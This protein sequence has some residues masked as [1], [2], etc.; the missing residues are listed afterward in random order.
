MDAFW[1]YWNSLTQGARD[2][3]VGGLIVVGVIGAFKMMGVPLLAGVRS[4]ARW[5]LRG[6]RAVETSLP[7][8]PQVV[9]IR[10]PIQPVALPQTPS[11]E[12]TDKGSVTSTASSHLIPHPPIV[13]FVARRDAEGREILACLKEEL[14]PEKTQ[15]VAL[16]GAGG[17]GKTTLAAESVRALSEGYAQRVVWVSA[18][19]RPDFT[20]A[21]L[22]DEIAGQLGHPEVRPL[23]LEQK[24][25]QLRGLVA[26]APT[27]I[28]LDNF[29]TIAETEQAHCADWLAN[30]ASC[31]AII[32]SRDY[33]PHARPVNIAAMSI[34]EAQEFVGRLIGQ[35]RHPQSFKG[36]ERDEII[37]AADR[38]PL[39]LQWII[40][41]IDLA[42]QPHTV[43]NELAQ[44]KGDA[45]E[46]V[47]GRSFDLL[48]D[49]GRAALLALSLFVPSASRRALAE[50]A[51]FGEDAPRL[52]AAAAQLAELWLANPTEGNERFIVEG[53][54]RELAKNLLS[55]DE[56]GDEFRQRFVAHFLRYAEAHANTTPEDFDALEAEKDNILSAMDVA[57]SLEDWPGVIRLMSAIN[58]DGVN[59]LLTIRGYWDEAIRRGEQALKA[60]H[61]LRNEA[62]IARFAHNTAIIF[63]QR[64]EMSEARRIYGESLKI[65]KKLG[66]QKGIASTL[67]ELA[68]LAQAQGELEEARRLY[69]ESLEIN[70]KLDN[71]RE[72]AITLHQLA[73]LAQTQG[74]LEKAR[75]LYDESLEINKKL[76]NHREIAITLHQLATLAQAQGAVEQARQ[77]YG[78]SLEISEKLSNQ[79]VIALSLHNL[80]IIAQDQ[81]ELEEARRLYDESLEIN[82]K[83]GSQSGIAITLH[84]LA[85]LAQTQGELEKARRLYDESLE[86]KKKLGDR[87]GIASTLHELARLAQT[88]GKLEKARRLYDE[89]LEIKKK[90]GDRSGI[91]NTLAQLGSLA[92]QEGDKVEAERLLWESLSIFE[93]LKSPNAEI[94]RRNLAR[95]GGEAS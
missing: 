1:Q 26:A 51:G 36:L 70:K 17:V 86:I 24:E 95:L 30:R 66:N 16:C 29:E 19:G 74:E 12:A 32:T 63:Q 84:Q 68:R 7:P 92:A 75:R 91:A 56:R 88:Q 62:V 81:G 55:A 11:K 4:I 10:E 85:T 20:L 79:S 39:V 43:L 41:Q 22:L 72:I 47:F 58:L 61:K 53:L 48:N 59:G 23:T 94:V 89:S 15:L 64:G 77:L 73:T 44:G 65:K 9:V 28:V 5:I 57:F 38:N 2:G 27:L 8:A 33:V 52:D 42:K 6:E 35:A 71:H 25:E 18:D 67:H 49:D 87:S 76:D 3:I 60:A 46:R 78:E 40:K 82:K 21:T 31:S 83:L 80:A 54:T 13:G 69:D 93:R 45:A 34:P 50:V 37:E 90:L 14:A